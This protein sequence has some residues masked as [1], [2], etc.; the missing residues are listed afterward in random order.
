[1]LD[2]AVN[3]VKELFALYERTIRAADAVM[4]ADGKERQ[5]KMDEYFALRR[6]L[7]I[8]KK[9]VKE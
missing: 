1:M 2:D 3:K 4:R 7:I 8:A 5:E 6:R 9:N